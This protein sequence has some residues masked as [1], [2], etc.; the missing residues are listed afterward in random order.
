MGIGRSCRRTRLEVVGARLS[1]SLFERFLDLL[2]FR[3]LKIFNYHLTFQRKSRE[4]LKTE[5]RI[6]VKGS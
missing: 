6:P 5:R 1:A 2:K 3:S 4:G